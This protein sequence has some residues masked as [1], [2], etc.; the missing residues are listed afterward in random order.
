MVN[1]FAFYYELYESSAKNSLP[2]SRMST[3]WEWIRVRRERTL[4]N[5]IFRKIL[6]ID[7]FGWSVFWL[8]VVMCDDGQS[9]RFTATA[10]NV[11]TAMF[12]VFA[13]HAF[14]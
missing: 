8:F 4:F 13:V 10:G 2:S 6:L 12:D 11:S 9:Q 14:S 5:L 3:Q 7:S 1:W